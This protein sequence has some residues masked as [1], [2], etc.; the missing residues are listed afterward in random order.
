M[1]VL[2]VVSMVVQWESKMVVVMV[3]LSAA[4]MAANLV[5]YLVER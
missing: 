2:L 1:V 4:E 3:D 5:G